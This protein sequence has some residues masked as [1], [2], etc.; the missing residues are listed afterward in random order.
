MQVHRKFT[1]TVKTF[2]LKMY[3]IRFLSNVKQILSFFL[4]WV[5]ISV[6]NCLSSDKQGFNFFRSIPEIA[7]DALSEF[8]G[9][10]TQYLNQNEHH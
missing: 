2:M 7:L 4:L 5:V 3:V 9:V 6:W 10:D 8:S 1:F